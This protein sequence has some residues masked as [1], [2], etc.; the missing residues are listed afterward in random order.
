MAGIY[1]CTSCGVV[2]TSKEDL[3]SP[4]SISSKNEYC[5]ESPAES[6]VMCEPMA[7]S[8]EYECGGCGRPTAD[9]GL[10]CTPEKKR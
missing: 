1:E 10:V 5:G 3:C 9:P 2:T 7:K 4:R 8:L 6:A